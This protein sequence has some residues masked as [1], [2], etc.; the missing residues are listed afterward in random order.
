MLKTEQAFTPSSSNVGMDAVAEQIATAIGVSL[1]SRSSFAPTSQSTTPYSIQIATGFTM[2]E[3]LGFIASAYAGNWVIT[4]LGKLRMIRTADAWPYRMWDDETFEYERGKAFDPISM[5]IINTDENHAVTAGNA[6]GRTIEL[7]CPWA[8]QTMAD[9][10]L[11]ELSQVVY[12]PAKMS[13]LVTPAIEIGDVIEYLGATGSSGDGVKHLIVNLTVNNDAAYISDI[14]TPGDEEIDHEYPY[15]S[16]QTR[17]LAK[18]S[19]EYAQLTVTVSGLSSTVTGLNGDVSKLSQTVSGLSATVTG[20]ADASGGSTST[21]GW[22]LSSSGFTLSAD[23][24]TVMNVT[25]SGA[26]FAGTVTATA[27]NIGGC[28]IVNGVLQVPTAN[29]IGTI[30]AT[31]LSIT[32]S[33]QN[34]LFNAQSGTVYIGGFTVEKSALY[35]NRS[36]I[37]STTNGIYI[38]TD[39]VSVG[40]SSRSL[41]IDDIG[42]LNIDYPNNGANTTLDGM[43]ISITRSYQGDRGELAL[44]SP[45][46]DGTLGVACYETDVNGSAVASIGMGRKYIEFSYRREDGAFV[47]LNNIGFFHNGS[48]YC[49]LS[50]TWTLNSSPISTSSD[51][52]N[53]DT[54][55]HISENYDAFFDNL[56][57]V[58]Y[59]LK[60]GTSGR[61]HTGFI[62][63]DVKSALDSANIDT[64]NFAGYVSFEKDDK[65]TELALRYEEFISLNTW[66]IQKLKARVAELE[67]RVNAIT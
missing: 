55:S 7:F 37:D 13:M 16:Q 24:S 26:S 2:R 20:K 9:N 4:D 66:Q 53:K 47:S 25:S 38:G 1:D 19:A 63:Q 56:L 35:Y 60:N 21:F 17:E 33:N 58:T 45:L 14:E 30:T 49:N 10:V 51:R 48:P 11:S 18:V 42:V 6:S 31:A 32:D 34:L 46:T 57:P 27:G 62:A 3:V 28:S 59:K 64:Q 23:G 39:G 50:G 36:A 67:E 29:I 43:D 22:S 40:T 5:V 44:H 12:N 15:E 65:Q 52:N 54:I 41:T 8:T 61:L